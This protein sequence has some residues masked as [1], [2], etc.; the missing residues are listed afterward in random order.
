MIFFFIRDRKIKH[1][2]RYGL[3]LCWSRKWERT[4]CCGDY[5]W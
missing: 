2:H 5:E 4:F 3:F 1:S